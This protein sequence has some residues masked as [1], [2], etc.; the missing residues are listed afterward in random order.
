MIIPTL[1]EEDNMGADG[2]GES[3]GVDVMDGEKGEIVEKDEEYDVMVYEELDIDCMS[4]EDVAVVT[5]PNTI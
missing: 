5:G 1:A 2:G 4:M 3:I